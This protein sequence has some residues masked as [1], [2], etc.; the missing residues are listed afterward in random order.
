MFVLKIEEGLSLALVQPSFAKR[1]LEIVRQEREY[2][3]QW[4]QWPPHAED[5][6]FF[7]KWV[8][9]CLH[10]YADGKSLSCAILWQNQVV[11]NISYNSIDHDLK[12][13]E[14]GYW[15][16][17]QYQGLG[18]VTKSLLKLIHVAFDEL[19]MEKVQISVAVGNEPSKRVCERLEFE[20][21]GTITRAENINGRVVD[22]HIYGL[23]RH[24]WLSQRG[25]I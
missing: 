14:V 21:E 3:G 20:L 6:A 11:G 16:S 23:S 15:V 18:I 10:E 12:R 8:Q 5:E 13:V 2:L 1:Y 4:L 24:K 22:H 25:D 17:A 7:L 19:D 9:R